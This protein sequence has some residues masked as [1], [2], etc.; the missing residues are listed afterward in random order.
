[1]VMTCSNCCYVFYAYIIFFNIFH[2]LKLEIHQLT[3][4]SIKHFWLRKT[5]VSSTFLMRLRFQ[6]TAVNRITCNLRYCSFIL[7]SEWS[8][9]LF[10]ISEIIDKCKKFKRIVILFKPNDLFLSSKLKSSNRKTKKFEV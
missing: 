4:K 7:S 9:D 5:T 3:K 6:G 8:W 1:M 2:I 10:L